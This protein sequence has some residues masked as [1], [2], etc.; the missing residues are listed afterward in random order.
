MTA[1]LLLI[2]IAPS[3]N[4]ESDRFY[5]EYVPKSERSTL[6]YIEINSR[7]EIS[8]A[9]AELS[10]NADYAEFRSVTAISPDDS[11]RFNQSANTVKIAFASKEAKKGRLFRAGFKALREGDCEFTLKVD[12]AADSAPSVITGFS[13]Y[14]LTVTFGKDDVSALSQ[15][16]SSSG[17]RSSASGS[18]SGRGGRSSI[19][20][21]DEDDDS[22]NYADI[23]VSDIR[24]SHVLTYVLLGAGGV[25][26]L[27]LIALMIVLFIRRRR[28]SG[29]D[30][31][32]DD[33]DDEPVITEPQPDDAEYEAA[34]DDFFFIE[35]PGF[36]PYPDDDFISAEPYEPEGSSDMTSDFFTELNFS[37]T[38]AEQELSSEEAED[39]N[40]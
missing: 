2:L 33:S 25:V 19:S 18:S 10:F 15:G 5:C 6:F 14:T 29:K 23:S 20:G 4:A 11:V 9:A 26:L 12:S 8:A 13:P 1:L 40:L 36:E 31:A 28:S 32:E 17:G 39:E 7:E 38:N 16:N 35:E 21:A 34:E 37:D 27:G 22:R 30:R 24:P 3:A